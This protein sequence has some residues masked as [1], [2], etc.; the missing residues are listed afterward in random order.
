MSGLGTNNCRSLCTQPPTPTP[1]STLV[2]PT[3]TPTSTPLP[4]FYT[5]SMCGVG[6][7]YVINATDVTPV[8]GGV[9]K[10]YSPTTLETMDGINC[11]TVTGTASYNSDGDGTFGNNF[12]SCE[13][14]IPPTPTPTATP[15]QTPNWQNTGR[16]A[17]YE[18]CNTYNVEYDYNPNSP[19]SGQE[20]QGSVV[21]YNTTDCSGC[22]G[23]STDQNWQWNETYSCSGCNRHYVEQQYN[24]CASQYG[25][26]RLGG[27][28]EYNSTYC[29][30]CCGQ[31][32][33]QNWVNITTECVDYDLYYVQEQQNEC[34]PD[35]L[36][37]RRGDFIESNSTSCGYTPTPTPTSYPSGHYYNVQ[38]L[39]PHCNGDVG[40]CGGPIG[41][42]LIGYSIKPLV[43]GDFYN[44]SGDIYVITG[45]TDPQTYD[46]DIST[47]FGFNYY[48]CG[49]AVGC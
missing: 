7:G 30:G 3:P 24:G 28:A 12:V 14:C 5:V 34:A 32:T 45:T 15:D 13:S 18:T 49:D 9:Y 6:T 37:R 44:N 31:S 42:N 17:C 10:L 20:R 25:E 21:A 1:T 47:W 40:S 33:T 16:V 2:P 26:T 19:T 11:W 36:S 46:M 4:T 8:V 41:G 43:V 48:D 35:Y 29:G 39:E 23:Q 27:V 22:C 38:Q